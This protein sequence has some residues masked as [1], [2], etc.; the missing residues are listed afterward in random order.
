MISAFG[1]IIK[2]SIATMRVSSAFLVLPLIA[3]L[4]PLAT[5]EQLQTT[6]GIRNHN[7]HRRTTRYRPKGRKTMVIDLEHDD[8]GGQK[9]DRKAS[10]VSDGTLEYF[11]NG[12]ETTTKSIDQTSS[13]IKGTKNDGKKGDKKNSR[14]KG[15]VDDT[16]EKDFFGLSTKGSKKSVSE[17]ESSAST[18]SGS[19]SQ[20]KQQKKEKKSKESKAKDKISTKKSKRMSSTGSQGEIW[21]KYYLW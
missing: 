10:V 19:K 3:W 4:W 6:S 20:G 11:K 5:G 8:T 9:E 17:D 16:E 13:N 1:D 12:E 21:D 15:S 2:I 18:T 7:Q 14:S